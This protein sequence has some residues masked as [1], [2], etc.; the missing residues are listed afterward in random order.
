[1]GLADS[2]A[3]RN[4]A[5][6][7]YVAPPGDKFPPT[8]STSDDVALLRAAN[9][10]MQRKLLGVDDVFLFVV[11]GSEL[12]VAADSALRAYGFP[13][14]EVA[15]VDAADP[16]DC[17]AD[18]NNTRGDVD[19][20]IRRWLAANHPAALAYAAGPYSGDTFWW[21]GVES[22][23][24]DTEHCPW[25]FS[26]AAFAAEL[27]DS[28]SARASTWLNILAAAFELEAEQTTL[29]EGLAAQRA[30]LFAATLCQWL[31]GFEAASGNS[32][33]GFDSESVV[34]SLAIS[35]LYLGFESARI[36][37]EQL[38]VLCDDN[39]VDIGEFAGVALCAI[40]RDLR[41]TLRKTLS[42]FFRGDSGLL[43]TLHSAIWPTYEKSMTEAI[44]V[45]LDDAS[46]DA[47]G[48]L[49]EPWEFVSSGWCE[50]AD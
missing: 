39:G 33:N 9:V 12:S 35:P 15:H 4:R 26:V 5:V 20:V 50:A 44:G 49:S 27:P 38:E 16:D 23:A 41:D 31:H 10:A 11:A 32:F 48:E 30:A 34:D 45:L 28:H 24:A 40:T 46:F 47:M 43:W 1:M 18:G 36:S 3:T 19:A 14:I 29:P 21:T 6:S 13:N 22:S 37:S 8:L 17:F 25:P 2:H 7:I 42:D